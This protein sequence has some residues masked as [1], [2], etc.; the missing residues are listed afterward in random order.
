[1]TAQRED[2]ARLALARN[3]EHETLAA[4]LATQHTAAKETSNEVCA[5][6][7]YNV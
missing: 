5:L 2:M 6:R 1:M 7:H 3:K 4:D